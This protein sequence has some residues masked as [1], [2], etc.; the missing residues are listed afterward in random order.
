MIQF[1]SRSSG[2]TI[3]IVVSTTNE[4]VCDAI[5]GSGSYYTNAHWLVICNPNNHY[6][7][8]NNYNY[9]AIK[10]GKIVIIPSSV[11]ERPPI[12]GEFRVQDVLGSTQAIY[13]ESVGMPGYLLSFNDEG[14]AFQDA[15]LKAKERYAQFELY[16]VD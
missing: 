8:H 6:Y 2:R 11:N 4:L 3:Q 1:F 15:Q 10:N 5:G 14:Q 12:E 16:L 7:F 9:L 13:L